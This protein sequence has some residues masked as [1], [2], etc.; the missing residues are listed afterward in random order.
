MVAVTE[1]KPALPTMADA[2]AAIGVDGA[3]GDAGDD[4]G[5]LC[6]ICLSGRRGD[7]GAS[8]GLA[9]GAF[10]SPG[11]RVTGCGHAFHAPCLDEWVERSTGI[12]CPLC[13]A[14]L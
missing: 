2:G 3:E 14:D 9:G 7:G 4:D 5:W 8:V 1:S 12:Q 6:P 10:L 13:R 11:L